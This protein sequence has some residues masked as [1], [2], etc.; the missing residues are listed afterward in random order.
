M[1]N[2]TTCHNC[3]ALRDL[4]AETLSY[5]P[6]DRHP[7]S[8]SSRIRA[9]LAR[10]DAADLAASLQ[11]CTGAVSVTVTDGPIKVTA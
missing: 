10:M 11:A 6:V 3:P 7:E 9:A 1:A 2:Q 4:L 5:T 8:L